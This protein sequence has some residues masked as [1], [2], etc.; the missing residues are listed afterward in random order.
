MTFRVPIL[1]NV[2]Y[3]TYSL[4]SFRGINNYFLVSLALADLLVAAA[5]MT[6]NATQEISGR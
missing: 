1:I 5:A 2:V 3:G 6:L 4:K